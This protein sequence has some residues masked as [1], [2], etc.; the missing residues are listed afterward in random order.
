M[1]TLKKL[2]YIGYNGYE[3][4]FNETNKNDGWSF[5]GLR[6]AIEEDL[7]EARRETTPEDLG[8]NLKGF[9]K[10]FDYEDF[11]DSME[12]EWYNS[13]DVQ[14]E[15]EN[16]DGET[17]YLGFGSGSSIKYYFKK[18]NIDTFEDYE[19]HFEEIGLTENQFDGL[20]NSDFS[21]E[22]INALYEETI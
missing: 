17:L 19:N 22:V 4:Y 18:N 20:I 5:M 7:R 16:E 21:I 14:A 1:K 13:H 9:E 12:E 11:A 8:Y 10:W 2:L 3:Y 15:I 6:A